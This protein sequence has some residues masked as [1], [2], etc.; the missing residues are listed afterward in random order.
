MGPAE[1]RARLERT[2]ETLSAVAAWNDEDISTAEQSL[3]LNPEIYI[4]RAKI[5]SAAMTPP[6]ADSAP[7]QAAPNHAATAAG[8]VLGDRNASYGPPTEDF[9]R[10]AGV[11]TGLLADKL[12][13]GAK[14]EAAEA[15]VLMIGLKLCREMHAHKPDNLIDAH[16][17]LFC[18]DWIRTGRRPQA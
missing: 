14:I 1:L 15:V 12:K 9:I 13:P 6:A 16:G 10:I 5:I 8:L 3:D 17:Y 7:N 11:F 4:A 18:L 2:L